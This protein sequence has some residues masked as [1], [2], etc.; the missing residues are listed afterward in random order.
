M[1]GGIVSGA[2]SYIKALSDLRAYRLT[3]Y[4]LYSA[5]ASMVIGGLIVYGIF[6]IYDDLGSTIAMVWVW[7]WGREVV[8][9]IAQGLSAIA[10]LLLFF[11]FYKYL[12][13]ILLSPLLSHV[14]QVMEKKAYGSVHTTGASFL[15][16]MIRG[17]RLSIRNVVRELAL[18]AVLLLGG[19]FLPFLSWL[20]PIAIFLVQAYYAGFG[21]MDFTLERF[22]NRKESINYVAGRRGFAVGNGAVFLLLLMIPLFGMLLAPFLGAVSAA[23]VLIPEQR[24]VV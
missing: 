22:M 20:V 3:P 16:D 7:D 2:L 1:I 11:F 5:L 10:A 13:F 15:S 14:S 17:L 9:K 18:T 23:H 24:R 8:E 6:Q 19:V 12:V 21:N 4:L